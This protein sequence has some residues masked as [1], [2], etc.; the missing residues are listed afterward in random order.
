VKTS[1]HQ[2]LLTSAALGDDE[3]LSR[4]VRAYHDRVYRFGLRVCR[5]GFDADDAVQE[6]FSKLTKR[7]DVIAD[8]GVLSWLFSVVR[9]ACLRMLR[10]FARNRRV[11]GEGAHPEEI[12]A[13]QENAQ[14]ALERQ[15]LVLSVH[16][17]IASLERPYRE[18][19][20]MRDLEGLSGEDTCAVLG[21]EITA[22]KTRLH[23]AR[24]KLRE[25]LVQSGA[26]AGPQRRN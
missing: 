20:V 2:A 22:M 10:R 26:L 18:V 16:A 12:P 11:I 4:L 17:A 19:I 9:N 6:A 23:R 21:L 15:E 3:A 8:P 7:R 14:E 13:G 1:P 5:D 24:T 25:T